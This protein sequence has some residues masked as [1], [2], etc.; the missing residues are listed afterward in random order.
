MVCVGGGVPIWGV[1]WSGSHQCGLAVM[2]NTVV[3][4]EVDGGTDQRSLAVKK[5]P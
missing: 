4:E 2:M 3:E 5:E 1:G